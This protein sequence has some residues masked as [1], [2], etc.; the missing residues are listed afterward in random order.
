MKKRMLPFLGLVLFFVACGNDKKTETKTADADTTIK[1]SDGNIIMDSAAMMK[2]MMEFGTPGEMHKML[3]SANG[4][5][6]ED[7]SFWMDPTKPPQKMTGTCTNS[8][9]M[10]GLYQR[11]VFSGS[12]GGMPYNGESTVGFDNLKRMFVSSWLDNMGSGIMYLTGTYDSATKK[13]TMTG[14]ESDPAVMKE[15][16][17]KETM[18][19][20]DDNTQKMEM[21]AVDGGKETKTMEIVFTRKK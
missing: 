4:E 8:M 19:F 2:A 11:S 5:W 1:S 3:A 20:V 14:K 13:I 17:L 16:D 10:N 21:F 7:I 9:I 18:T 6:N 12:M 15:R